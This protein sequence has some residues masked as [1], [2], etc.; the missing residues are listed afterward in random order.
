MFKY[1]GIKHK[2]IENE[3]L[4]VFEKQELHGK[5]GPYGNAEWLKKF[6]SAHE[7]K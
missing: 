6:I 5:S 1:D 3:E 4:T 7:I 2:F